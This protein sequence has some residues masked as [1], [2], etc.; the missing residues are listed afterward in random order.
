MSSEFE[1]AHEAYLR[2]R[3]GGLA[4]LDMQAVEDAIVRGAGGDVAGECVTNEA[5]HDGK[6]TAVAL[7]GTVAQSRAISRTVATGT[8]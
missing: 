8:D 2:L 7:R 3:E 6:G 5:F 4:L 1:W